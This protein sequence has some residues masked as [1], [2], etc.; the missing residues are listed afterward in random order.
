MLI[1]NCLAFFLIRVAE[2]PQKFENPVTINLFMELFNS[3]LKT[4]LFI[5]YRF[6]F[7]SLYFLERIILF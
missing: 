3:Y 1:C 5:Y 4:L 7:I 6:V 2:K